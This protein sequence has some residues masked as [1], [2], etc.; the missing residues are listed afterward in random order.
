MPYGRYKSASGI[1]SYTYGE[2]YGYGRKS[3]IIREGRIVMVGS[4]R[5]IITKVSPSVCEVS[6]DT[7]GVAVVLTSAIRD[8]R[9]IVSR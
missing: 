4:S 7:G 5:G 8:M 2:K 1:L 9:E 3:F 6:L